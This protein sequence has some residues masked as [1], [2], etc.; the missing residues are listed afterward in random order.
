MHDLVAVG[1]VVAGARGFG[2]A[3]D[4]PVAVAVA[5]RLGRNLGWETCSLT[6]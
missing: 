2:V 1:A 5:A 4:G 3:G 6:E